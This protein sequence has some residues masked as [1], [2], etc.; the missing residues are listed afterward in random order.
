[1]FC[2]ENLRWENKT[3]KT[4]EGLS[5]K[6]IIVFLLSICIALVSFS[7]CTQTPGTDGTD[8]TSADSGSGSDETPKTN[9]WDGSIAESFAGGDGSEAD[10]FLIQT[11]A[12]LAF[13]AQEVNAGKDYTGKYV[14]LACDLDLND[15]EWTPIGNGTSSF[16]GVFD[17]NGHRIVNLKITEGMQFV[18]ENS[19]YSRYTTGLFGSCFNSVIKNLTV[20]NA[21]ITIH[22][23][24]EQGIIMA[25][26]LAGIVESDA[27]A[28]FSN[29]TIS[30]AVIVNYFEQGGTATSVAIGGAC[31]LA[32][33][34]SDV[35][36][37]S[38]VTVSQ[39]QSDVQVS[40]QNGR[41]AY[42]YVGGVIG[43]MALVN[44]CSVED[45]ASD[46]SVEVDTE[47]CY[48]NRNYF[49]AFGGIMAMNNT[50]TIA[51]IFSKV[52]VNKIYDVFHG[53]HAYHANAIIGETSHAKQTDGSVIGG[54]QFRNL[55]GF[56]EQTDE[57]TGET[58]TS[59]QLYEIPDHAIY[60]ETNCQGC[61]T[62]PNNHGFDDAVW[63]LDDLSS[64]KLKK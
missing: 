2:N 63:N 46:L 44:L 56:V 38:V 13:L 43:F 30:D 8:G 48:V 50:V 18:P 23:A 41:G 25:G 53:Y 61:Q 17:G 29:I 37:S 27:T 40:I 11:A 51:N 55:F 21:T 26:V 19:V 32:R 14:S 52:A 45:C 57:Q 35:A 62:L 49:G 64:P 39:I 15:I 7:G 4:L 34:G 36:G 20:H 1:M 16:S 58:A 31:G 42:N 3:S 10:P 5:M 28:E 33:T 6:Q 59:T 54:F 47:N 9:V 22:N 60:T 12:Q 24:M